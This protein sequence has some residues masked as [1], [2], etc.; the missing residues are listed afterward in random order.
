MRIGFVGLG[1]QGAPI[2]ERMLQGG[3]TTSGRLAHTVRSAPPCSMRS[4]IPHLGPVGSGQ[5]LKL[6]NNNL[7][8]AN[9]AMAASALE[10]AEALGVD[11]QRAADVMRASSGASQGLNIVATDAVLQKAVGPTSNIPKDVGH[12]LDLLRARG[13]E[14]APVA[15]AAATTADVLQAFVKRSS[16]EAR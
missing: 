14:D 7:C 2:A 10:V 16:R 8:Y 6:L 9:A 5:V 12:F 11:P 13:L 15:R 1:N 4:A 3:A